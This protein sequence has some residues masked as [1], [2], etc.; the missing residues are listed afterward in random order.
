MFQNHK[1]CEDLCDTRRIVFHMAV[2]SEKH[3]SGVHVHDGSR[4]RLDSC[5]RWPVGS[6]E[7][8]HRSQLGKHEHAAE[9]LCQ[10]L[11]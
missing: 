4:L 5:V 8:L 10:F 3:R 7:S 2:L 11:F 6:R 9:H 1:G